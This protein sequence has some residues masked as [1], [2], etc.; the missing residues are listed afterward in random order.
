MRKEQII[1][2]MSASLERKKKNEQ[3]EKRFNSWL[4]Q[5]EIAKIFTAQEKKGANCDF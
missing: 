4:C 3:R 2:K 5:D 1:A